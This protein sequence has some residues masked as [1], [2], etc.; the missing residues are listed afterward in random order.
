MQDK[1][2]VELRIKLFP[3]TATNVPLTNQEVIEYK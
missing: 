3:M 1:L 2:L